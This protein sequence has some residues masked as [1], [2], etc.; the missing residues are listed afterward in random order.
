[1][2]PISKAEVS[3]CVLLWTTHA[4]LTHE[5]A[6]V[7]SAHQQHGSRYCWAGV[8]ELHFDVFDVALAYFT[9]VCPLLLSIHF[10]PR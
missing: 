9:L 7:S 4:L 6:C 1:M 10:G 5:S 2:F 3:H 8:C